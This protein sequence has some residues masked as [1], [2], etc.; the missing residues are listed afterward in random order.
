LAKLAERWRPAM[1]T[2][3]NPFMP[4][5]YRNKWRQLARSSDQPED[6]A[7]IGRPRRRAENDRLP[8]PWRAWYAETVTLEFTI[9]DPRTDEVRRV[10]QSHLAFTRSVTPPEGVFALDQSGLLHPSVTLFG[11]RQDGVLLGVGALKMLPE[12]QAELKS[13][14][15]I[16]ASR[17]QGVAR[18]V[19]EML[20]SEALRRNCTRLLLET[21]AMDAFAPARA[22]YVTCDFSLCEPF[23]EYVGSSTSV[24]MAMD[25][26]GLEATTD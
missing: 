14:H 22:L 11:A 17:R 21:G 26:S 6:A 25:L 4:P 15:T 10:L 20:I 19:V 24:C 23:G 9:E 12:G 1:E 16:E 8:R 2:M 5:M 3:V 7:Q 13:M 18:F